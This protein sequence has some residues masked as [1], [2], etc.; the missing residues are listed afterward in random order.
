MLYVVSYKARKF[1]TCSTFGHQRGA[2]SILYDSL[3]EL[4]QINTNDFPLVAQP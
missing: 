3:Q 1:D 2:Q 4:V